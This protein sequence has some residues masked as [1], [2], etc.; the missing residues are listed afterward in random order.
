MEEEEKREIIIN[1][2]DEDDID[3]KGEEDG[4]EKGGE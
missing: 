3:G 1:E 2:R 4:K